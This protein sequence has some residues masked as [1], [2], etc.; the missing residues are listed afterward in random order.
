MRLILKKPSLDSDVSYYRPI[1][2]SPV[3]L[4]LVPESLE[5]AVHAHCS[6]ASLCQWQ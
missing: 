5:R 4:S 2:L 3:A 1:V 6:V